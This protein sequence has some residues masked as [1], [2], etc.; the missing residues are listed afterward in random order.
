MKN[1]LR[2][3]LGA[4][5]SYGIGVG[6]FIITLVILLNGIDSTEKASADEQLKLLQD[7]I[8]RAVV[9]CYALEGRYPENLG[10]LI[11]NYNVNIDDSKFIVHYMI[12]AEN[13]MPEIDILER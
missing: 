12:F 4:L 5:R 1:A 11:E 2:V 13:I 8:S 7:N 6:L 10:Y 3:F 9:S